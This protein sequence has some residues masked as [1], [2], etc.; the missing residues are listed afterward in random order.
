MTAEIIML[1]DYRKYAG[2][3]LAK[4]RP[5][6][7]PD[8]R[9][10]AKGFIKDHEALM[11]KEEQ[12]D[13]DLEAYFRKR[14]TLEPGP[15]DQVMTQFDLDAI[16]LTNDKPFEFTSPRRP[17][18]VKERLDSFTDAEL[19]ELKDFLFGPRERP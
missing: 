9:G 8:M 13:R 11:A 6:V 3:R 16:G 19:C 18:Y 5:L 14:C 4:A 10:M 12:V 1:K 17:S 15:H 2:P 7:L